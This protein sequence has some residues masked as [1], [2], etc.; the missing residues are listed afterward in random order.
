MQQQIYF[1][2]FIN[3]EYVGSHEGGSILSLSNIT[4]YLLRAGCLFDLPLSKF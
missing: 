1:I 3:G 2:E 4:S